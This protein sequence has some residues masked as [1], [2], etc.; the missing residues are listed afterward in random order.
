M[1]FLLSA[2]EEG[3]AGGSWLTIMERLGSLVIVAAVVYYIFQN[4]LPGIFARHDAEMREQRKLYVEERARDSEAF[5][6]AIKDQRDSF[7]EMLATKTAALRHLSDTVE[8]LCGVVIQHDRE[9][10]TA[11]SQELRDLI[12]ASVLDMKKDT[13]KADG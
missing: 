13:A 5:L 6:G 9:M 3:F 12:K 7:S 8:K 1:L 10:N 2:V 11:H 4:V